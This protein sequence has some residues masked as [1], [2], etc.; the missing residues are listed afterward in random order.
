MN[1]L[2][3]TIDTLRRDKALGMRKWKR[4][5]HRKG[6]ARMDQH[7]GVAHCSDPNY[8]SMLTGFSPDRWGIY[9]QMGADYGARLPTLQVGLKNL[10][11]KTWATMPVL[12]PGF[13]RWG[14]D[15]AIFGM[16]N[17]ATTRGM[18]GAKRVVDG[19]GEPW[20]GFVRLM[21]AHYPYHGAEDIPRTSSVSP[22]GVGIK[23]AYNRAVD[24]VDKVL[25]DLIGWAL[26]KYP[27][28]AI[29]VTADHGELLGEHDLWDHLWSLYQELVHV[30]MWAY[31][32]GMKKG[33]ECNK[34]TQHQDIVATICDLVDIPIQGTGNSW[35]PML[36]GDGEYQS[37]YAHHFVGWG[38]LHRDMWRYRAAIVGTMKYI[39]SWHKDGHARFE[40]YDLG[41]GEHSNILGQQP[42]MANQCADLL[43][44]VAPH[45]PRQN[46][47]VMPAYTEAEA[48]LVAGRL[49]ALGYAG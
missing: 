31:I 10:G 20:F 26:A 8:A 5:S 14:F 12:V 37:D 42:H 34:A 7:Y 18:P 32:P 44:T 35:L 21:D 16:R 6:F 36:M 39:V 43:A 29:F 15:E 17:E 11:Y 46:V 1:I 33:I 28:T 22:D 25:V 23:R 3:F 38:M 41:D 49:E 24:Y 30:P 2:L 27:D 48:E 40:L 4:F 19:L 47:T 9:T 13:Y 45:F